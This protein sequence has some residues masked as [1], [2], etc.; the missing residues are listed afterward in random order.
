MKKITISIELEKEQLEYFATVKGCGE[1]DAS[2]FVSE[3][4]KGIITHDVFNVLQ[5]KLTT[6]IQSETTE[7]LNNLKSNIEDSA[8]ITIDGK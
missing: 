8:I 7:K 4:F 5:G 6:E 1:N 2:E 3:Y